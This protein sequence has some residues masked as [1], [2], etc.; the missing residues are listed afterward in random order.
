MQVDGSLVVDGTSNS[1]VFFTRSGSEYWSG[2]SITSKSGNTSSIHYLVLEY[3]NALSRSKYALSIED[4]QP[5]IENV[6]LRFNYYPLKLTAGNSYT[7]TFSNGDITDNYGGVMLGNGLNVLANSNISNNHYYAYGGGAVSTCPSNIIQNNIIANNNLPGIEFRGCSND[8]TTQ[9]VGNRIFGNS[10][11]IS[12]D[13]GASIEPVTITSNLIVSNTQI[14]GYRSDLQTAIIVAC[15]TNF[16]GNDI[17]G[18]E[19]TYA[20]ASLIGSCEIMGTDNWWGTT[21][22][23]AISNMINDY[24]D[25]FQR[26]KILYQPFSLTSNQVP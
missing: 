8:D 5:T 9:I 17:V 15:D 19:S 11:A 3:A 2:L 18:N 26:S 14:G 1:P 22:S 4:S 16:S 23:T 7:A 6:T 24:Y 10:G 20:V 21:D 25:D 13:Y 12:Y